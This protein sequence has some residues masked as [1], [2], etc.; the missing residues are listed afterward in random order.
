[1]LKQKDRAGRRF[2]E[3]PS[4]S[5]SAFFA[6]MRGAPVKYRGHDWRQELWAGGCGHRSAGN[7]LGE[8]AWLAPCDKPED[9]LAFGA[10][11]LQHLVPVPDRR[12]ADQRP[13]DVAYDASGPSFH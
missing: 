10:F 3:K 12:D 1:M 13:F 8:L 6:P 11:V 2:K 4:R 7:P 9:V 5:G